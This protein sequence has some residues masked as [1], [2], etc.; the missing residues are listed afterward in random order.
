MLYSLLAKQIFITFDLVTS[1]FLYSLKSQ[2]RDTSSADLFTYSSNFR[3]TGNDHTKQSAFTSL[4]LLTT[5]ARDG[6]VRVP[7]SIGGEELGELVETMPIHFMSIGTNPFP[8]P[9]GA[10]VIAFHIL[11]TAG[12]L[13]S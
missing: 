5:Y 2:V 8:P 1:G 3:F 10:I 13:I 7:L 9:P 11:L 6:S 12:Q 4:S